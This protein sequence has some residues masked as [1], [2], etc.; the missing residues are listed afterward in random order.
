MDSFLPRNLSH[1]CDLWILA[2]I[3]GLASL[4]PF[5]LQ[6]WSCQQP[7]RLTNT[8][9]IPLSQA[10]TCT[11]D[12]TSPLPHHKKFFFSP[13]F[14]GRGTKLFK[15]Q[16]VFFD[17]A[18]ELHL[19]HLCKSSLA[20]RTL[21]LCEQEGAKDSCTR[22]GHVSKILFLR[23]TMPKVQGSV[24]MAAPQ[25][26]ISHCHEMPHCRKLQRNDLQRLHGA[27]FQPVLKPK[28]RCKTGMI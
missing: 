13:G 12:A 8:F 15:A 3:S 6:T 14:E 27:C 10:K 19:T 5:H 1:V 4:I 11:H 25:D 26:C 9:F 16:K 28:R 22:M 21:G 7:C 17:H 23:H 20:V 24:H 2:R 18:K